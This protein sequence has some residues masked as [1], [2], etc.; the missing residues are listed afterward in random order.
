MLR[1]IDEFYE[2]LEEPSKSCCLALR[3]FILQYNP[4]ITEEW[5]YN[6]PFFYF[7]G[8]MFCYIWK[9]KKTAQPYIGLAEGRNVEHP[10]LIAEKRSRMKI[11]YINPSKDLPVKTIRIIFDMAVKHYK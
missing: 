2:R 6:M 10:L 3:T 7:N 8:K 5:K 1:A 11:F 9:D 4:N